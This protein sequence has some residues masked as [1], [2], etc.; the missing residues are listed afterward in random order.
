MSLSNTTQE[1]VSVT[2]L[3]DLTNSRNQAFQP[4]ERGEQLSDK[5]FLDAF[6]VANQEK[7]AALDQNEITRPT[8]L[9]QWSENANF[10]GNQLIPFGEANEKWLKLFQIL[11]NQKKK[12]EKEMNTYH[13]IK[14]VII[15]PFQKK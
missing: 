3:R 15:S 13:M 12:R 9:V 2:Q 14:L 6:N 11:K 1:L 4:V 7:Y 5:E 8:M 10:K